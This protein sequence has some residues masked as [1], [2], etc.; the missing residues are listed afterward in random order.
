MR[1]IGAR[2]VALQFLERTRPASALRRVLLHKR[3]QDP[4]GSLCSTTGRLLQYTAGRASAPAPDD[5]NHT[6]RTS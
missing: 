1:F 2:R 5:L 3:S 4:V 6:T